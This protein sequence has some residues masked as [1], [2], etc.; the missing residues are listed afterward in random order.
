MSWLRYAARWPMTVKVPLL[1][2]A[3]M[4]AVAVGISHTVLQRLTQTQEQHLAQL[5][6]AYLDGLS[7]AVHPFVIRGDVWETFDVLDRARQRY[8]GVRAKYAI[9]T[10][11]D[12]SVLAA[13]NPMRFP[14]ATRLP[15]DVLGHLRAARSLSLDEDGA[16]AWVYRPLRDGNTHVG[17]IIAE[18]DISELIALRRKALIALVGVNGLLTVLF[19][20]AGYLV[21]RRMLAPAG[22]LTRHLDH[23]LDGPMKRIDDRHLPPPDSEFGRL[24]RRFNQVADAVNEREALSAR[25][26]QKQKA[27]V[28]GKL[29]SGLA[30]EVNNPLGGLFNAV[31]MIREHGDDPR[32]RKDATRLLERGL[33]GIRNLVRAALL[34]YKGP[35]E[36]QAAAR[37]DLD[38]LR[39]LI[40]TEVDRR[41]IRL[42]WNVAMPDRLAVDGQAAQQAALNLLLNACAVS[43]VDGTVEFDV[44]GDAHGLSIVVRDEGPGLPEPF[45]ALLRNGDPA[46]VPTETGLGLWTVARLIRQ[47][48]GH[49]DVAASA[50]GTMIRL[51]LPVERAIDAAA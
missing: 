26:A 36:V 13:S 21:V 50:A 9:V 22:V 44:S 4:I 7:T 14:T 31:A 41:R 1:V 2:A 47:T 24:F 35:A 12:E 37:A 19:A 49:A 29:A 43:P 39:F 38:D 17:S 32:I 27:A 30:H 15:G 5:T 11:P 45:V 3:L 40:Q 16:S 51:T 42:V 6:D 25:L 20:A 18:I 8:L 48:G 10:L 34:T 28:I 33:T 46:A 23:A